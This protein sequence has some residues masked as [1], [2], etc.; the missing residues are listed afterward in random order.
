MA[1]VPYLTFESRPGCQVFLTPIKPYLLQGMAGIS[2]PLPPTFQPKDWAAL[3]P[4]VLYNP[5]ILATCLF[6]AVASSML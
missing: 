1:E 6:V 3:P 2:Y 4:E 5:D